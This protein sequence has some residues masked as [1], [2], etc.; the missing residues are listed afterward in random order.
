MV[1]NSQSGRGVLFALV[2]LV[3]LSGVGAGLHF[4]G[5]AQRIPFLK[6]FYPQA[7]TTGIEGGAALDLAYRALV[8]PTEDQRQSGKREKTTQVMQR[9]SA[10][11][12]APIRDAALRTQSA[13]DPARLT[14]VPTVSVT[15]AP[16]AE[17]RLIR[18]ARLLEAMQP[19]EAAAIADKM[20]DPDI[21]RVVSKMRERQAARLL[22]ALKPERAAKIAKAMTLDS[23]KER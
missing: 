7:K 13:R 5:V 23:S 4:S 20:L 8:P 14:S 22:A 19:E 2:G 1:R 15:P 16:S 12:P 3:L 18:V 21:E 17:Q 6:R 9:P 10:S 11:S